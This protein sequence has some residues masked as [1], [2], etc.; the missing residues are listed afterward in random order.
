MSYESVGRQKFQRR[1]EVRTA[2]RPFFLLL[3]SMRSEVHQ[4][5]PAGHV[6]IESAFFYTSLRPARRLS[7]WTPSE[8]GGARGYFGLERAASKA[9]RQATRN[10]AQGPHAP[11][12]RS[13]HL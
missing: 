6:S 9:Q 8:T 5:Q 1:T 10:R 11:E 13:H 7:R 4:I 2:R 12:N 3:R